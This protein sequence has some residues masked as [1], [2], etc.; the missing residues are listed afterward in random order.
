M[1][2]IKYARHG[3]E[4]SHLFSCGSR[5]RH[6]PESKQKQG[7]N[8]FVAAFPLPLR[9]HTLFFVASVAGDASW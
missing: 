6:L 8:S 3:F 2:C 9:L 1:A 7:G 4:K 5:C